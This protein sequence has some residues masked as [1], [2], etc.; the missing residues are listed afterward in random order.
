[1]RSRLYLLVILFT[2]SPAYSHSGVGPEGI[3]AAGLLLS[4]GTVLTGAG[5]AIG[6]VEG[7]RPVNPWLTVALTTMTILPV[8]LCLLKSIWAPQ[9]P[10]PMASEY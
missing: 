1:M 5:I 10:R 7:S 8:L 3:N 2:C 9:L 4:N 6:Q